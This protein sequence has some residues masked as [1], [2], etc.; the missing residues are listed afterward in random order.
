MI[1]VTTIPRVGIELDGSVLDDTL[2]Q[3]ITSVRVDQRLDAPTICEVTFAIASSSEEEELP[4]SGQD[5]RL[6]IAG[7][8]SPLFEG[9]VTAVE[10]VYE[11]SGARELRV[12]AY[13]RLHR[14]RK[15]QHQTIHTDATVA[16]I[17]Q[18]LASEAGLHLEA[19][20][21]G[22]RFRHLIQHGRNDLELLL[23]LGQR[24]GLHATTRGDVVHLTTLE[25]LGDEVDLTLGESLLEAR[26][27]VNGD[28]ACRSVSATGWD[29]S[30]A[31]IH[32]ASA[33]SPRVGRDV[34]A[35]VDPSEVGGTGEL[36]FPDEATQDD[37]HAEALAQ[38]ELDVRV[39]R[40]VAAW[41]IAD[42][43][44]RLRPGTPV[45]ISGVDD[46]IAGRYV[47]TTATHTIDPRHGYLTE[48]GTLPPP[49]TR[50]ARSAIVT[51]GTVTDLDD[52]D[53]S[54]RVRVELP[55]YDGL[56]SDW[57]NVVAPGAGA[58][59]GLVMLPSVGDQ[60]LLLLAHDDPSQGVV[61]GGL[62]GTGGTP[63]AAGIEEGA[64][65][66]YAI[67]TEDGHR[68]S[69]DDARCSIRLEDSTGSFLELSP[70]SVVVHALRPLTI[71]APGQPIL[72]RGK[73]VDFETAEEAE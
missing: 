65:R 35:E 56:E 34:D 68:L 42:G 60:V 23:D 8:Y 14:L 53:G 37:E 12:R 57:L 13:D 41:G 17:A 52:P 71:E 2:A 33:E 10:H 46:Q 11:P 25:G 7:A 32:Q 16:D 18:T 26:F 22:P 31:E 19:E 5:L 9:D 48:F 39:A 3:A 4:T 63:D 55:T 21:D 24:C 64:V 70:E 45:S 67:L 73:S 61:V 44:V 51:P 50:R 1:G 6:A 62:Y 29:P 27:E 69:F 43:D 20:L 66:R 72:I 58:S 59:K 40:E 30:R 38:A 36:A 28:P 49:I 15:R 54:G 47:V